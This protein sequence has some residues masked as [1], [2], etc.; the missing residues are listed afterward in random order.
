MD[1]RGGGQ[2][3][4]G[5]YFYDVRTEGERELKKFQILQTI[6]PDKLYEILM[7]EGGGSKNPEFL[8]TSFKYCP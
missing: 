4:K 7:K 6:S 3:H 5:H 2:R 8:Q 1:N